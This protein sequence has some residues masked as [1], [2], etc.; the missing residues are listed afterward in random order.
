M[1]LGTLGGARVFALALLQRGLHREQQLSRRPALHGKEP[2]AQP[3]LDIR[4]LV[5]RQGRL[6]P[7]RDPDRLWNDLQ[8]SE[9]DRRIL[10]KSADPHRGLAAIKAVSP[11]RCRG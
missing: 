7:V 11:R 5:D 1:Y 9:R 10:Y 6:G 3:V 2:P 4:V 8:T